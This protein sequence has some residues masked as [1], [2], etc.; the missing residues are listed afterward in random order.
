[1]IRSLQKRV[2]VSLVFAGSLVEFHEPCPNMDWYEDEHPSFGSIKLY[3]RK[4][5]GHNSKKFIMFAEILPEV[6]R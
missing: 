1:M 4:Y 6:L 3:V 5:E 2:L